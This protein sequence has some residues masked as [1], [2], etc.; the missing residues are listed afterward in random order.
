MPALESCWLWEL[1]RQ[2]HILH[3]R[4]HLRRLEITHVAGIRWHLIAGSVTKTQPTI[5]GW[6]VILLLENTPKEIPK[7]IGP[8]HIMQHG[9]EQQAVDQPCFVHSSQSR[10]TDGT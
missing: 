3:R 2:W 9:H 4:E 10:L 1:W 7:G 6:K 8:V 5:A